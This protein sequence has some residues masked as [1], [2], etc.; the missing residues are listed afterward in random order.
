MA[1]RHAVQLAADFRPCRDAA[2]AC[3][4]LLAGTSSLG[5]VCDCGRCRR[6]EFGRKS[7][8]R[9]RSAAAARGPHGWLVGVG[10]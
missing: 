6:T 8:K 3:G 7:P 10:Q 1:R 4:R 2:C 5:L 9:D